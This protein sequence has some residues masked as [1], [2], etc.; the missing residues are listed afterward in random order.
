[1]KR[2]PNGL[3]LFRKAECSPHRLELPLIDMKLVRDARRGRSWVRVESASA[4]GSTWAFVGFIGRPISISGN[5]VGGLDWWFDLESRQANKQAT[6]QPSNQVLVPSH[7]LRFLA[8]VV[9]SGAC[10]LKET[11]LAGDL[12][13]V[14]K[15]S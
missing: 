7:P 9:F 6:K 8:F 10:P 13:A 14:Q 15:Y 4:H 5:L 3:S 2:I 11:R 12:N 1:M